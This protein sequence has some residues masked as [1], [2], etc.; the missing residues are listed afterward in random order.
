ML[1]LMGHDQAGVVVQIRSKLKSVHE[2]TV[3]FNINV[4]FRGKRKFH[5][6]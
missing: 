4:D 1:I 6:S 5:L 3:S 2:T